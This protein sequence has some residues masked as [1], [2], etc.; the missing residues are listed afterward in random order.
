MYWTAI[1]PGGESWIAAESR[2]SIAE[3]D[4]TISLIDVPGDGR[5]WVEDLLDDT[6]GIHRDGEI[7][8]I[9][10]YAKYRDGIVRV[11]ADRGILVKADGSNNVALIRQAPA[12]MVWTVTR[13]DHIWLIDETAAV[14]VLVLE[15]GDQM[16]AAGRLVPDT[17]HGAVWQ[18][19]RSTDVL[20][21]SVSEAFSDF[22]ESI[23]ENGQRTIPFKILVAGEVP[24]IR[25][26]KIPR[27]D[28]E[29][30]AARVYEV[31]TENC[32]WFS[33]CIIAGLDSGIS[34]AGSGVK[35]GWNASVNQTDA[36]LDS[37]PLETVNCLVVS[38]VCQIKAGQEIGGKAVDVAKAVPPLAKTIWD[39]NGN[40]FAEK[41]CDVPGPEPAGGKAAREYPAVGYNLD[42]VVTLNT[43]DWPDRLRLARTWIPPLEPSKDEQCGE[44][45]RVF[46]QVHPY[47]PEGGRSNSLAES[48]RIEI[49]Y[50]VFYKEDGG[51]F[52]IL[53]KDHFGD[54]EGFVIGLVRTTKQT[55]LCSSGF[56]FAGGRAVSHSNKGGAVVAHL[57]L[58]KR[59][60]DDFGPAD[61][62][63][64][65][66][67]PGDPRWRLLA[68]EGKH[69]TYYHRNAKQSPKEA[70]PFPDSAS[71]PNGTNCESALGPRMPV[72]LAAAA[73]GAAAGGPVLS[74][75]AGLTVDGLVKLAPQSSRDWLEDGLEEC[76][77]GRTP[78]DLR[79]RVELYDE[80]LNGSAI[81]LRFDETFKTE[82]GPRTF[83]EKSRGRWCFGKGTPGAVVTRPYCAD[84]NSGVP[85][86]FHVPGLFDAPVS[87]PHP[88]AKEDV[89][90]PGE[91]PPPEETISTGTVVPPPAGESVVI[92]VPDVSGMSLAEAQ[93]AIEN[94]GLAFVHGGSVGLGP[95][96]A[97]LDGL[98]ASQ[99][100]RAGQAR[101]EG[102]SVTVL[103]GDYVAPQSV[104]VPDLGGL[105]EADAIA[106]VT[107]VGLVPRIQGTVA[108]TDAGM[109]GRVV[110]QSPLTGSVEYG[111]TV[112]IWIA[113][114]QPVAGPVETVSISIVEVYGSTVIGE[115]FVVSGVERCGA[116]FTTEID[117]WIDRVLD[118]TNVQAN[119]GDIASAN[120]TWSVANSF[121][122]KPMSYLQPDLWAA[123]LGPFG[124]DT[125]P[126]DLVMQITVYVTSNSGTT[127]T[128]TTQLT[129]RDC[130]LA[131]DGG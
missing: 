65:C 67:R 43:S 115:S 78:I 96:G 77:S 107:S 109:D 111:A 39:N 86:D 2:A 95:S 30:V 93:A 34:G 80:V 4:D 1:T 10:D 104:A 19:A 79:D 18:P 108:T 127:V 126:G 12:P 123:V 61:I 92:A 99:E 32:G 58:N 27:N 49:T 68:S 63:T 22:N 73:A 16:I 36:F 125:V 15:S 11:A 90:G 94:V 105:P 83:S 48:A 98:V 29:E 71:D 31:R 128:G 28:V 70:M 117:V 23:L 52:E 97:G 74:V 85:Y 14:L 44:I 50:T 25:V 89:S 103:V 20:S 45:I 75:L 122:S 56:E 131:P 8:V 57:E 6:S 47:T 88:N 121:G 118:G 35:S 91:V 55:G 3:R 7:Y 72:A 21:G 100:P 130:P 38:M 60:I 64:E 119:A 33:S 54:N 116:P 13:D 114:F 101:L 24:P 124:P 102:D 76:E 112:D 87:G 17:I 26:D 81:S 62:G 113:S 46:A 37:V 9:D 40:V 41:K 51:R 84:P 69:A 120:L 5:V 106:K 59:Q 53:G 82:D 66:P 110:D 129:L 42:S